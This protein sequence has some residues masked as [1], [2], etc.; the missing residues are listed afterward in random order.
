VAETKHEVQTIRERYQA[1]PI[2][3]LDR[4]G[5]L[6][7]NV[8]A[9]HVVHPTDDELPILKKHSVG[10][11]HC[12]QSNMKLASG[13]AP[14]PKMLALD[15]ALGLGTDGPAS[16]NDLDLWEEIDTAAKL[17]K[18]A[19][20]DPTVISAREAFSLATIGGARAIHQEDR[21]G[22]LET[23]KQADIVIVAVDGPHQTPLYDVYSHLA[24]AVKA[25]DVRTVMIA[26]KVVVEEREV[27]TLDAKAILEEARSYRDRIRA[28]V[29]K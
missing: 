29:A 4:L 13:I 17:H 16:N 18:V 2:V 24:Y 7:P 10:V 11:A 19:T 28:A 12:P 21:L 22:S 14:V 27:K 1:T 6:G 9:A 5:V 26:G 20:G 15:L 8:I 23:G 25:S 3:H